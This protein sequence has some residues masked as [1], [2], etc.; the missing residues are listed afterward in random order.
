MYTFIKSS[1]YSLNISSIA[2]WNV[3]GALH[4][5]NGILLNSYNPCEQM[6]AVNSLSFSSIS[7]CQYPLAKSI[8]ENHLDFLN[9]S[10]KSSILGSG[11]PFIFV[12][13]FNFL[14][15]I[16]NLFEPSFFPTITT[17]NGYELFDFLITPSFNI[18]FTSFLIIFLVSSLSLY[19]LCGFN[20]VSS[21]SSIPCFATFVVV[22][23]LSLYIQ[24][25][26][27]FSNNLIIFLFLSSS[28][29]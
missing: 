1:I 12:F 16:Q 22:N 21:F 10:N 17:G 8:V 13:L 18:L 6:N 3:T 23:F 15:S 2:L 20:F 24:I 9:L 7:N 11:Y 4:N 5:P 19:A 14:K 29:S 26:S 28:N 25:F 27:Y